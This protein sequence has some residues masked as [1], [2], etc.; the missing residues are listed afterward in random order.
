MPATSAPPGRRPGK[1]GHH[2]EVERLAGGRVDLLHAC[3]DSGDLQ[4]RRGVRGDA[5]DERG[6]ANAGSRRGRGGT[7]RPHAGARSPRATQRMFS[8]GPLPRASSAA[9][10]TVSDRRLRTSAISGRERVTSRS[11]SAASARSARSAGIDVGFDANLDRSGGAG[12]RA[13]E[14]VEPARSR[15]RSDRPEPGRRSHAIPL[16]GRRATIQQE[17]RIRSHAPDERRS[18][19]R[20]RLRD[21]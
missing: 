8:I 14:G 13:P 5:G 19:R 9:Q 11:M 3:R 10:S 4:E 1:R 12:G 20:R 7:A 16:A 18:P 17:I 2:D 15:R 21:R 6:D